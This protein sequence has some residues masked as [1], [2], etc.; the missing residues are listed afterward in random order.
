MPRQLPG[1]YWDHERQRYFPL[2]SPSSQQNQ[3]DLTQ[4]APAPRS[5][6]INPLTSYHALSDLRSVLRNVQKDALIQSVAPFVVNRCITNIPSQIQS[7]QILLT[8]KVTQSVIP[9]QGLLSAFQVR[10]HIS[11]RNSCDS[12]LLTFRQDHLS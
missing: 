12:G 4:T 7:S 3:P 6:P 10:F 11:E 9:P 5:I 8:D 1:L 2:P